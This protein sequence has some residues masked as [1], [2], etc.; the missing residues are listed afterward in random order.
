M[1]SD[2]NQH[3]VV[4]LKFG[5]SVL[6]SESDL[7][8]CIH[9]AYRWIRDGYRVVAVVSAFEGETDA[10]LARATAISP[11]GSPEAR[12]MLLA[13]GELRSAAMLGLAANRSGIP[14]RVLGPH[15]LG[16]RT[17]GV[18][19]DAD[20]ASIDAG[21][22]HKEL[23]NHALLVV[24]GFV[25]VDENA[26]FTLLGRGGSDL[27]AIVIA[28]E[29]NARCRLVKDVAGL[30]EFDPA[31]TRAGQK[32][33]RYSTASWDDALALDGGIVQHK[34]VRFAK[35]RGMGFEV[36]TFAREDVSVIGNLPAR[37][38][39]ASTPTKPLRVSVLG[40]GVVG[41]GVVKL[42]SEQSARQDADLS[43]ARVLVREGSQRRAEALSLCPSR[44]D[45]VTADIREAVEGC[46]VV[47][48][49]IGGLSPARE[50]IELALHAGKHVVTANKA[51]IA[52]HGKSLFAIA[53]SKGVSLRYSA[54]VGGGVPMIETVR[55]VART[56]G[57]ERLACVLNG[58]C[59]Y[60]LNRVFD[61][62]ALRDAVADAQRLGFAEA[63]PTRDLDGTDS[64]D[65]L[66]LL[67]REAWGSDADTSSFTKHGLLGNEFEAVRKQ[68]GPHARLRLVA[69]AQRTHNGIAGGVTPQEIVPLG[70]ALQAGATISSYFFDLPGAGNRLCVTNTQGDVVVVD[71]AGAGRWPTAESVFADLFDISRSVRK[72]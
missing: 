58:T 66:L 27:T 43:L 32:P 41:A 5:G 68:A 69:H 49:L 24:P 25:G 36:G 67:T 39:A 13:T 3:R 7:A 9:E 46:D 11:E 62:A 33:Q 71:G 26:S 37:L 54:A 8:R 64:F 35:E 22:L 6:G 31:K 55:W 30:Y 10:L 48:E 34:A 21:R 15:E 2:L 59:N 70:E 63:D 47:V 72:S 14:S 40:C 38:Y 56:D 18:G 52:A 45:A 28:K 65:K 4:V 42:L 50:W 61:G 29:L 1:S 57:V 60:V 44:K 19:V 20:P 51:L 23:Q 16:L 53:A 12:A 17:K